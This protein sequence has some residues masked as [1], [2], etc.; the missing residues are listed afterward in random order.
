MWHTNNL[1]QAFAHSARVA[2]VSILLLAAVDVSAIV[3]PFYTEL[4][5]EEITATT[6]AR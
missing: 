2:A 6:D 1:G 5:Q 4:D 3:K